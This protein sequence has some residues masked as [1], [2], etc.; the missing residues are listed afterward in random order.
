VRAPGLRRVDDPR[1]AQSLHPPVPAADR[2][3]AAQ[4]RGVHR[5]ARQRLVH[6]GQGGR[7]ARGPCAAVRL[8]RPAGAARGAAGLL[9]RVVLGHR[10]EGLVDRLGDL[11]LG[12]ARL[13]RRAV[14]R[15]LGQL[16]G[17]VRQA[18]RSAVA[19]D[20]RR[21]PARA[22]GGGPAMSR[23]LDILRLLLGAALAVGAVGHFMPFLLPFE[24]VHAWQDPMAARLMTAFDKSG[25]LAV[26]M[27]IH[28]A[29]GALL[30]INRAVPFALAALMPVNVCGLYISLI[31]EADPALAV[32]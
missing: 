25:L 13:Q 30:L 16:P 20:E 6:R 14:P 17:N 22:R 23:A 7:T 11:R 15:L 21:G 18:R 9:H 12:R 5:A 29:A 26:A 8:P 24:T 1:R 10:A 2:Q 31:L 32:L 28:L 19:P 4:H 27:F 3:P